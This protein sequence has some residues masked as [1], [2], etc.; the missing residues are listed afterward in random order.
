GAA[1]ARAVDND[2][3]VIAVVRENADRNGLGDRVETDTTD[4]ADVPGTWDIVVANIEADVLI[5]LKDALVQRM[6]PGKLLVLSGI[7]AP[8]ETRVREAFLPLGVE[9][10]E[11]KTAGEW[12]A[13]V[14]RRP[15]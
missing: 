11:T 13:I 1:R 6:K 5:R 8:Q 3:D 9:H 10:V 12:V 14:L 2:A 15:A 4:V 7:L